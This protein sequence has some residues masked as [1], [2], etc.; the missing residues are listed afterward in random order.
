MVDEDTP[1]IWRGPMVTS[2][3]QQLLSETNW[4][5]LDYLIVDLPPGTGDIQMALSRILPQA[6]MV[7]FGTLLVKPRTRSSTG[8]VSVRSMCSPAL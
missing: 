8:E 7:T 3:L 4:E 2:A 1:M 5:G 6:E